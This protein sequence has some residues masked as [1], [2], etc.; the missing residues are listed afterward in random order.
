MP[1]LT[2]E[3][4]EL[5]QFVRMN[6]LRAANARLCP[7]ES[8]D[9]DEAGNR[10]CLE[11]GEG[12]PPARVAAIGAVRCVECAKRMEH[13]SRTFASRDGGQVESVVLE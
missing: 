3:A 2:D 8:P 12:I 6:A 1:D 10:F 7:G 4:S 13:L 11:C 5:E 9:E